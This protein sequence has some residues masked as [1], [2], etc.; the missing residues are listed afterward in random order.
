MSPGRGGRNQEF[1]LA[2]MAKLGV[3]GICGVTVLSG[4]TDGEDGPTDAA[5]AGADSDSL[6]RAAALDLA[7][8]SSPPAR[9]LSILRG[10]RWTWFRS[11]TDRHQCD[12]CPRDSG[13]VI[14]APSL[15]QAL[16]VRDRAA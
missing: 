9:C 1:V 4:G 10:N 5:G 6:I 14:L 16:A 7:A 15:L 12:G 13:D 11:R 2:M 3:A 8:A